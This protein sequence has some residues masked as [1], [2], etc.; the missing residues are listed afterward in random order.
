VRELSLFGSAL[1]L[2]FGPESDMDFLVSMDP[3]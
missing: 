3:E 1:R 2:D